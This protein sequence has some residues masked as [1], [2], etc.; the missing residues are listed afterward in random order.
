MTSGGRYV[1]SSFALAFGKLW[2]TRC[3]FSA[4][5]RKLVESLRRNVS[6]SWVLIRVSPWCPGGRMVHGALLHVPPF[7]QA[8][9]HVPLCNRRS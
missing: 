7:S 5:M 9:A 3:E 2:L 8:P 6:L 1:A 4:W